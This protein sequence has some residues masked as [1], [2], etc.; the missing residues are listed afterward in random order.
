MTNTQPPKRPHKDTEKVRAFFKSLWK[1][2]EPE[3]NNSTASVRQFY[4]WS[5]DKRY[6]I[7]SG[8]DL[9]KMNDTRF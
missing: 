7:N 6:K 3:Q 2:E 4:G 5:N 9:D 8:C 1:E